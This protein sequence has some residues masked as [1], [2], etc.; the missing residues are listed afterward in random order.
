MPPAGRKSSAQ[1][2]FPV[3]T[4]TRSRSIRRARANYRLRVG[5][6]RPVALSE[7]RPTAYA[8]LPYDAL[9]FFYHQRAGTPIEARFVGERWARPAG[10]P[11]EI[12]T[13][14]SGVDGNGNRWPG[15]DYSLDV[16][17]GWYDAGDHGKYVVNGGIS[18]WTLLNLLRGPATARIR[19][20]LPTRLRESRRQEMVSPI[21][22]TRRD[23]SL[24][25]S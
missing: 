13:C 17:G 16:T 24:N 21:C 22:S 5:R 14:V 6:A 18:L 10:H 9:A 11:R 25:S 7:C 1:I 23:T 19:R 20:S 15:C 8:K 3:S 4:S 12:V 2:A